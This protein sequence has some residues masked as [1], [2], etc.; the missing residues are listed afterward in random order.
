MGPKRKVRGNDKSY[1]A[2]AKP[3]EGRLSNGTGHVPTTASPRTAI[4]ASVEPKI[5]RK[6]YVPAAQQA[7]AI[8][9]IPRDL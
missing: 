9:Q 1:R 5:R 8:S 3:S 4:V 7:I 2:N 6:G